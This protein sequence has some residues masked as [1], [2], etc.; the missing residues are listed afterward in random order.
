MGTAIALSGAGR[1]WIATRPSFFHFDEPG[2]PVT[3]NA[4]RK[5]LG[6]YLLDAGLISDSEL[7]DA[8]TGRSRRRSLSVTSSR[9][10]AS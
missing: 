1:V 7:K 8:L 6:E 2:E 4:R 3:E 10:P 5:K 9:A